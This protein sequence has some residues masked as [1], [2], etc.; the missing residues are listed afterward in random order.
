[1]RHHQVALALYAQARCRL[2]TQS[3]R[4]A[5]DAELRRDRGVRIKTGGAVRSPDPHIAVRGLIERG[6]PSV[7]QSIL[8]RVATRKDRM[9]WDRCRDTHTQAALSAHPRPYLAFLRFE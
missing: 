4:F 5:V 6:N 7:R 8:F 9:T 2:V 3:L 1:D